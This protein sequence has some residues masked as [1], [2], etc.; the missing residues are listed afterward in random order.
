MLCERACGALAS[1]DQT[2][3]G[4]M[5]CDCS[6]NRLFLA[7]D[8]SPSPPAFSTSQDQAWLLS[9]VCSSVRAEV[10]GAVGRPVTF[11]LQNLDGN[12]VAW[13]FHHDVIVAVK[14]GSPP[15]ALFFDDKYKP[16]LAFPKNGS[17]LT[18]SPLRV[19]DAGT[20]TAKT[21]TGAKTTF[22]LHVYSKRLLVLAFFFLCFVLNMGVKVFLTVPHFPQES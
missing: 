2:V 8:P 22:T 12:T 17:A 19:G 13:S 1:V 21:T 4:I 3:H 20:Y 5:L 18:I 15:E 6:G 10:T 9:L 16:R 11:H 14:F 7:E